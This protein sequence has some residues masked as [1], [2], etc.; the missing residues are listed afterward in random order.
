MSRWAGRSG[1]GPGS[2]LEEAHLCSGP[3]RKSRKLARGTFPCKG[4]S[5]LRG[6]AVKG[7]TLSVSEQLPGA[8]LGPHPSFVPS[9]PVLVSGH[10]TEPGRALRTPEQGQGHLQAVMSLTLL[11]T[12]C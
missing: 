7:D 1:A 5:S 4:P 8:L 6:R 2:F 3:A 11:S 9:P 12:V 10:L